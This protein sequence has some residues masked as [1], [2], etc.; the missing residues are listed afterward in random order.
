MYNEKMKQVLIELGLSETESRVYLS[1]LALGPASV[2]VIAKKAGVSRTAAYELISSLQNKGLAS[3]FTKGKKK[4]FSAEDP[5]KLHGY[6]KGRVENMKSQVSALREMVPELRMM[7]AEN[8]PKVRFFTGVE[9]VHALFRDVK[10]A[11]AKEL[12]EMADVNVVYD[13]IDENIILE[14]RETDYLKKLKVKMLHKGEIRNSRANTEYRELR[15]Q[16]DFEGLVW[17]YGNRIAYMNFVGAVEIVII[18]NEI[19]AAT[20]RHMFLAAWAGAKP[21][22]V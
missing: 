3:T 7:Q 8:Q 12:F 14:Y 20:M 2:Q 22:R 4:L 6:F 15:D 1:M 18:E 10:A 19:F 21:T 17:I 9:G 11:R 16:D 13:T 5:E